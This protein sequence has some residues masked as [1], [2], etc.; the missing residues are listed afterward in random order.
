MKKWISFMMLALLIL[1]TACKNDPPV[2]S[3]TLTPTI[4]PTMSEINELVTALENFGSKI[5]TTTVTLNFAKWEITRDEYYN[6]E[7]GE[8][9]ESGYYFSICCLFLIDDVQANIE[10]INTCSNLFGGIYNDTVVDDI[11]WYKYYAN[12]SG[13]LDDIVIG[14]ITPGISSG[15]IVFDD[16]DYEKAFTELYYE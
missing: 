15:E 10:I 11:R 8:D 14:S 2:A 7:A 5:G 3:P 13:N 9:D 1:S 12:P 16:K 4:A 6:T